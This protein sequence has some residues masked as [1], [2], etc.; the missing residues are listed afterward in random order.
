MKAATIALKVKDLQVYLLDSFQSEM[1]LGVGQGGR[2]P[3]QKFASQR[4]KIY[5]FAN[6]QKKFSNIRLT[7]PHQKK[8]PNALPVYFPSTS[9]TSVNKI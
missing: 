9:K 3:H 7:S 5:I 6:I 4:V 1:A 2:P 8:I